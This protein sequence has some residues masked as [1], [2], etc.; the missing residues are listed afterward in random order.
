MIYLRK[1]SV[2]AY[3]TKPC[4][5]Q[6]IISGGMME[7]TTI[8]YEK[9]GHVGIVRLNRPERMNAVIEKMYL[10]LQDVLAAAERDGE[11][12][13]LVLT[14]TVLVKDG[15]ERQAFCAGADL[16][17]HSA[18]TRDHRQKR[19]YIELAHETTRMIYECEKP[20]IAAVNGAAR[21]AGAEMALNCDFVLMADTAT[22][23]FPE[24]GLGTFVGGGVT[25]HLPA[26]VGLM[27][28]KELVYTGKVLNGPEAVSYGLALGSF[29]VETLMDEALKYA[30]VIAGKAPVSMAYA[31]KRLQS[32]YMHDLKTVLMHETD[33]ILSC[34][35]TEDWHEG[36]RA[37]GEKRKPEYRGQ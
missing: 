34:M 23:A 14:G 31:K 26:L 4:F 6:N 11:I 32:S 1:M 30:E 20:V 28:A 35:D 17:E 5:E 8:L 29:P 33:A 9:T 27:K 10:E 16:K 36:I 19:L 22:I 21:G 18:G 15:K 7:Y 3:R 13:V 2:T 37:F 25:S 24:T 12:R